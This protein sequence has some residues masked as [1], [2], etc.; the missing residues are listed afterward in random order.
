MYCSAC[1]RE[2][3]SCSATRRDRR[4]DGPDVEGGAGGRGGLDINGACNGRPSVERRN[5]RKAPAQRVASFPSKLTRARCSLFTAPLIA[6]LPFLASALA[7]LGCRPSTR[8][9]IMQC[10]SV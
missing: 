3:P 6:A 1:A 7:A 5:L 4:S 10:F 8:A 9:S 2:Q